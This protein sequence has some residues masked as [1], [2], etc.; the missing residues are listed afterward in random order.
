ML[1]A[2][3]DKV[4]FMVRGMGMMLG[5]VDFYFGKHV[6]SMLKNMKSVNLF[7]CFCCLGFFLAVCCG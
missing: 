7:L 5:H 6:F 4:N 3:Q 2:A 1:S